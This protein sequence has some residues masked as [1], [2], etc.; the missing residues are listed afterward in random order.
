MSLTVFTK[1]KFLNLF[2]FL[3]ILLWIY[4]ATSKILELEQFRIQ[5]SQVAFLK[6]L[7]G[8]LIVLVPFIE[9]VLA[10]LL[11]LNKTRALGLLGSAILMSLFTI[12]IAGMI[13]FSPQLPCSCGGII[14]NLTWQQHLLFNLLFTG[15]GIT[16][17]FLQRQY[18]T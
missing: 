4:A 6:P 2:A 1:S 5:I 15:L 9:Y 17:V 16:G 8:I 10:F 13:H 14:N 7:A 18:K 11:L 12:Y 3:F